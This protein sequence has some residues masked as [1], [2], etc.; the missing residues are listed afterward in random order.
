MGRGWL[1]Y[2]GAA[3][4]CASMN[5]A[6]E[7]WKFEPGD[8]AC[9]MRQQVRG[10][11]RK[12]SIDVELT[13][14]GVAGHGAHVSPVQ[15]LA[16]SAMIR[17]QSKNSSESWSRRAGESG[18]IA[19]SGAADVMRKNLLRGLPILVTIE[20]GG[21]KPMK[22]ATS[23]DGAEAAAA[24]F[25]E[26]ISDERKR[27]AAE[28]QASR[29]MADVNIRGGCSMRHSFSGTA[30]L[31][32]WFDNDA[33]GQPTF[34]LTTLDRYFPKGGVTRIHL[35][36]QSLPWLLDSEKS[37]EASQ[38]PALLL[39]ELRKGRPP[40]MFFEPREMAP[41][42]IRVSRDGMAE[43]VAMFDA[44]SAVSTRP[45]PPL[46]PLSEL[47][48]SIGE[49]VSGCQLS[50]AYQVES[51][52]IWIAAIAER[53]GSRLTVTRRT[54][55]D[56][57]KIVAVDLRDLGGLIE[58]QDASVPLDP[59]VFS[60]LMRLAQGEG[61]EVRLMVSQNRGVT[62]RFGGPQA[63]SEVAMFDACVRAKYPAR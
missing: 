55:R 22:Y 5:A 15:L 63:L 38:R 41:V 13:W 17:M 6:A 49:S 33:K 25:T 58:K 34:R 26:C 24:A 36:G 9:S 57:L 35:P 31:T 61:N 53:E 44:C 46:L 56:G 40:R 51:E 4:L 30:G 11:S 62:V 32:G 23:L 50:A 8:G 19:K 52:V 48:Y 12:P 20:V 37:D 21:R 14:H 10:D 45:R 54:R 47:D 18:P 42:E 3:A 29:W 59:Q 7:P 43:A 39:E 27:V 16:D 28:D 2:A 60:T 1:A